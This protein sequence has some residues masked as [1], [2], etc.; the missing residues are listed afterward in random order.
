MSLCALTALTKDLLRRD[1]APAI[2]STML[3]LMANR[4]HGHAMGR[5]VHRGGGGQEVQGRAGIGKW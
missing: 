2:Y 3:C 5:R 1:G 4:G